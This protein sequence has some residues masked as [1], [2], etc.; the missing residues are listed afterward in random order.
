LSLVGKM[1]PLTDQTLRHD[2][3]ADQDNPQVITKA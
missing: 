3:A 1:F 2:A